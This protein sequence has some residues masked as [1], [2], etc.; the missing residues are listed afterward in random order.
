[1]ENSNRNIVELLDEKNNKVIFEHLLTLDY[2]SSEYI[3]L[4]PLNEIEAEVTESEI[5]ILRV[6][7]DEKGDDVYVAIEDE[8]EL[9]EVFDAVNQI[10]TEDHG[11]NNKN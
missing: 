4:S 11:N 8:T 10:Y 7:Q 2:K 3:V 9:Y 6:E 5:V 1:M